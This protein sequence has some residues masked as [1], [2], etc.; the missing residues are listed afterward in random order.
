[1]RSSYGREVEFGVSVEP[2]ASSLGWVARVAKAADQ[3]GLELLGIQDHP[4]Q[5]RFLD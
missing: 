5:R 2:L 4:Y 1:M 3:A